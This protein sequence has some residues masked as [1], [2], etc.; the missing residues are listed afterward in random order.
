MD[1]KEKIEALLDDAYS[2][3]DPEEM[4]RLA[5]AVLELQDD[6]VEALILLADSIEYSEEKIALL[7]KA[8]ECLSDV[9]EGLSVTEGESVL[10]DDDGMLYVAV[11]QRLGFALFSEGRNGEALSIAK[12]IIDYDRD[13]ETLGH[14]LLYRVLLEMG[15]DRELLEETRGEEDSDPA[16][17]HSRAIASFR[18]SGACGSSYDALWKA[19]RS[20]PDIPFYILGY[21][22]EP[23]DDSEEAEEAYNFSLLF[24]DIWSSDM[25]LINWLARATILLGLAASLFPGENTEKMLILAD[26][27][28][29]ADHAENAMVT[30]ES[31]EDW[32]KLSREKRIAAS[33]DLFSQ[34]RYLP[35]ID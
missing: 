3:D 10:D 16:L 9:I 32:G 15:K 21:L 31:R 29:I 14:T 20:G 30:L 1:R 18:L 34:G 17:T 2:T 6:N 24:E 22:D 35:L 33:I 25:D 26:A 27:L 7:E 11:L 12:E 28:E 5:R 23:L 4:E 8:K 13:R 19:F